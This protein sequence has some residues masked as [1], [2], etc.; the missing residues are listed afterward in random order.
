MSILFYSSVIIPV[1]K[2][3]REHNCPIQLVK[4]GGIYLRVKVN[5]KLTIGYAEQCNPD[6]D[7]DYFDYGNHYLGGSDFVKYFD[8]HLKVFDRVMN[9]QLNLKISGNSEKIKLFAVQH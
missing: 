5:N 8:P 2:A 3:A 4:D 7:P 9:C 1:I 6:I